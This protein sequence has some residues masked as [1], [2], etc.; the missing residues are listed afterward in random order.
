MPGERIGLTS[1]ILAMTMLPLNDPRWK[2]LSHRAWSKGARSPFDPGAPSAPEELAR[3]METPSDIKRFR[4]LW[5]YLCSEGTAWAAAYAAVPYAVELARR[6][7]P[8]QR[9]EYLCF[10]GLVVMYSR[11]ELGESFE[12]EPYL[13]DS[14]HRALDEALPLLLET[15]AGQHDA[16]ETRYLLATAAA[17]KGQVKLGL[18]LEHLGCISGQCPECGE[19]VFPEELQQA[20]RYRLRDQDE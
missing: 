7:R 12:L 9:F 6:L 4:A 18:V 19:V 20:V 2:E 14:Y 3:L 15:L 5:P 11:P 16:T 1:E 8:E 13:E 17:L 10:I